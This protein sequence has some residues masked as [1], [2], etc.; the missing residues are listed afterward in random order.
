MR[1][2]YLPDENDRPIN[3]H[4]RLH[5]VF[6][7]ADIKKPITI[8]NEF[9]AIGV[10]DH[11]SPIG[12]GSIIN[13]GTMSDLPAV[14]TE[15]NLIRDIMKPYQPKPRTQFV[16]DDEARESYF[17]SLD[18]TDITTLHI[19]THGFYKSHNALLKA[20]MQESDFDH[21]IADR[22]LSVGKESLSGLVM[23]LG[24]ISWKSATITDEEDDILTSDEIENLSFPNLKLTVLSACETGLG[25][26][27]SE[28]VWGLNGHFV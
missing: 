10:S 17:K 11:N 20:A 27:D 5:R 13:R 9:M 4:Y 3:E 28:G 21:Y 19:A 14:K 1:L 22:A 7:L 8:G 15:F 12:G 16:L 18:G 23:R 25:D 2:D 24:N 26:V 6:H